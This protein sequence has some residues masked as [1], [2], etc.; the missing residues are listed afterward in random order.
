MRNKKTW[1]IA[2]FAMAA[3]ASLSF[4]VR[5]AE[6]PKVPGTTAADAEYRLGPEDVIDVFVWK[7]PE[8]ST[9]AVVR[10][11]G[12]IS[13]PLAGELDATGKTAVELQKEIADRLAKFVLQP[14]VNVIVKQV[15]SMKI[16]VL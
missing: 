15:N 7:E 4:V 3:A 11:D 6:V 5:A 9:N 12:R 10:P 14:V 8:L 16:S 1:S 2:I 13:L